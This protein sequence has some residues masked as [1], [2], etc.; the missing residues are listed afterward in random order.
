MEEVQRIGTL[1]DADLETV[2]ILNK[3]KEDC[4]HGE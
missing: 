2:R 4:N 3:A 1:L